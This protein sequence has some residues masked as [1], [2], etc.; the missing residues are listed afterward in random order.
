MESH[1]EELLVFSG[2]TGILMDLDG[3]LY[4]NRANRAYVNE[5]DRITGML[6][7]EHYG[8]E[9]A[10]TAF[11]LLERD[12]AAHGHGSKTVCLER[13]FGIDLQA[14]NRWRERCTRPEDF[15]RPDARLRGLLEYL[16]GAFSLILGTN[17]APGVTRRVLAALEIPEDV[18][19][20]IRTSEELGA[21]KPAERFFREIAR[22]AGTDPRELVSV[23][24]RQ[25]SD[26]D[27]AAR[28]GMGT[29]LVRTIEDV[30]RIEGAR[31][32]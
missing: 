7:R 2:R 16:G 9:D 1:P 21:A 11:Q 12:Q 22:E 25:E 6:V 5:V 15:L 28:L 26:L 23:G 3:T 17:N 31:P 4:C 19:R 32:D 20:L 30:Y 14:Q 24:D 29:W 18:F 27:P 13:L 8:T 10:H